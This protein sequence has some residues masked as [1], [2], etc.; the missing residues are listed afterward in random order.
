MFSF[1]CVSF[2]KVFRLLKCVSFLICVSFFFMWS[3]FSSV[4]FMCVV[5]FVVFVCVS[6]VLFRLFCVC[7]NPHEHMGPFACARGMRFH[8]SVRGM[9][10][11]AIERQPLLRLSVCCFHLVPASFGPI[12]MPACCTSHVVQG[13]RPASLFFSMSQKKQKKA[14]LLQ[15]RLDTDGVHQ[16]VSLDRA[17][18]VWIPNRK[19]AALEVCDF[20]II[21]GQLE[22]HLQDQ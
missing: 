6:F 14:C 18:N 22:H 12:H 20:V 2:K 5:C 19:D 15:L 13:H 10:P 9:N 21:S 11:E 8:Q 16:R 7:V 3:V 4:C 17:A 1:L